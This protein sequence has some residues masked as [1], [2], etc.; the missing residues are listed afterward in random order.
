MCQV[1]HLYELHYLLCKVLA[2]LILL[3]P[4]ISVQ[5]KACESD[6]KDAMSVAVARCR[7]LF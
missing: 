3:E 7:A 5:S 2:F 6:K 1:A 4:G